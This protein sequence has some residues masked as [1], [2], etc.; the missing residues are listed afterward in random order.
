MER[1]VLKMVFVF[2]SLSEP[3]FYYVDVIF[4]VFNP[5][6]LAWDV[7]EFALSFVPSI[8]ITIIHEK[9]LFACICHTLYVNKAINVVNGFFLF[10]RFPSLCDEPQRALISRSTFDCAGSYLPFIFVSF[11][12]PFWWIL[13]IRCGDT[14]V[15]VTR[16]YIVHFIY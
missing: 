12:W 5:Y 6:E 4:F 7:I 8:Y 2:L 9:H 3:A 15:V 14:C 10:V 16:Y 1:N 13:R 11:C